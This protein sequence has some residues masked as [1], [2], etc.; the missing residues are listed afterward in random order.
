MRYALLFAFFVM[1]YAMS[2]PDPVK[3]S[4]IEDAMN[5]EH[6]KYYDKYKKVRDSNLHKMKPIPVCIIPK[7]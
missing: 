6:S 2:S 4:Q 5:N 3:M 7:D 1:L